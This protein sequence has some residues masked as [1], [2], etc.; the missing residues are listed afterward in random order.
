MFLPGSRPPAAGRPPRRGDRANVA[1]QPRIESGPPDAPDGDAPTELMPSASTEVVDRPS[2][3]LLPPLDPEVTLNLLERVRDGDEAA[4]EAL[5]VRCVPALRRWLHGRLPPA[6]R[7]M[8]D[9]ADLVQ[10]T[11]LSTLRQRSAFD[12]RH[13]GA[14]Q[15]H[16]RQALMDRIRDRRPDRPDLSGAEDQGPSPL[17]ASIG[18]ENQERYEQAL[19]RLRAAD[20]EALINRLELQYSYEELAVALD[21]PT[22]LAARTTVMRAIRRLIE[23]IRRR[24]SK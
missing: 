15:A 14:L 22:P 7:G 13:Q 23:E 12:A 24:P 19:A 20:R 11:V 6:A 9:T 16:L 17:V 1:R 3:N 21:K 4:L 8:Q 18:F 10:E 5:L 2:P